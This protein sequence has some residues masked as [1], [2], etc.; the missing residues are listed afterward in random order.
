MNGSAIY[1]LVQEMPSIVCSVPDG[2]MLRFDGLPDDIPQI[3]KALWDIQLAGRLREPI[4]GRKELI[5]SIRQ[6]W[7]YAVVLTLEK[8]LGK[9]DK[10]CWGTMERPNRELRSSFSPW[11]EYLHSL[12][13]LCELAIVYSN[14]DKA[15]EPPPWAKDGAT[16][17]AQ[18]C[19]EWQGAEIFE[20]A[21]GDI[22]DRGNKA[23]SLRTDDTDDDE[24]KKVKR[25]LKP[26][27]SPV[28]GTEVDM[29]RCWR[30]ALRNG[31]HP[32]SKKLQED[33]PALARLY[34][35]LL[36]Q[37]PNK[38]SWVDEGW[39]PHLK[40][41]AGWIADLDSPAWL[42]H[43]LKDGQIAYQKGRGRGYIKISL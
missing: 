32:L 1:L 19:F 17:F 16:W 24:D 2:G 40:A 21:F 9:Q 5:A 7:C 6:H 20:A 10:A 4:D 15:G 41:Y 38:G 34:R 13:T 12:L 35:L 14:R 3:G 33:L 23:H 25:T 26:H 8:R 36:P 28:Y 42:S 29:H 11:V 43:F 22:G 31:V 39:K 30:K 18:I 27:T 37:V